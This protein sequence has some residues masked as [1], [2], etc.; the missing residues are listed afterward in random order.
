MED[1]L[2][3]KETVLDELLSECKT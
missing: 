2:T 3:S 1:E